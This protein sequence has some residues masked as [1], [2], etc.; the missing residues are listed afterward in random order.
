MDQQPAAVKPQRLPRDGRL[1]SGPTRIRS[2]QL[3]SLTSA[4]LGTSHRAEPVRNIVSDIRSHLGEIL[5]LAPQTTIAIGNG[6]AS[7]IWDALTFTGIRQCSAHAVAGVFG[8]K[9]ANIAAAA[10]HLRAPQIQTAPEGSFVDLDDTQASAADALCY[11]HNETSTG[12]YVP[13][14]QMRTASD[15]QLLIVDGTSIAGASTDDL[16]NIDVYYFSPQKA[17]GAD[18]GLWIAALSERARERFCALRAE[19]WVPPMFDLEAAAQAS[20]KNQTYNTPAVATLAL[21]SEQL[22]WMLNQGGIEW[23]AAHC[24]KLSTAVYQW[25]EDHPQVRAF[26]DA[27]YRSPVVATVELEGVSAKKVRELV[28]TKAGIVDIG[29]YRGVGREQLRIGCFPS[30]ALDDLQDALA[31]LTWAIS[32]ARA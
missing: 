22:R 31:W 12:V 32:E 21:L 30:V 16:S 29:G 4:P 8:N 13:T 2:E 3:A 24:R 28:A 5:P 18:G 7:L 9:F 26:A 11:T 10:P 27:N 15:D 1:G 17:L 14:S 20:E 19:R 23:A 25:A 6:G